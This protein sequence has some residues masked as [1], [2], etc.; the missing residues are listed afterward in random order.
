MKQLS[1]NKSTELND[2]CHYFRGISFKEKKIFNEAKIEFNLI[3]KSFLFHPLATQQLGVVSLELKEFKKAIEYFNKAEKL[4]LKNSL[5][6]ISIIY[7]DIGV[8]Y[9]HL[10]QFKK[11]E[12]YLYKSNILLK[13]EKD[14]T[15]LINSYF[16]I[17]TLYYDQYRDAEAIPYFEKAYFLSKK[18][19]DFDI[20]RKA[21]KNM[22]VV[23][24]NR[25]NYKKS[26]SL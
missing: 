8:C 21:S 23:E 25:G 26:L 17:A 20:K 18:V 7:A 19:N 11:A 1:L 13:K 15:P 2:F 9:L 24:E 4:H 6:K 14:T 3:S 12:E 5:Y 16:N 22:A 10:N